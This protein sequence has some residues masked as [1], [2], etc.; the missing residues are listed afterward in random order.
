MHLRRILLLLAL[1]AAASAQAPRIGRIEF[2]GLRKV[3]EAKVRKALGLNVG[4]ALPRSK[5]AVEERLMEV[6]GIVRAHLEATCCDEGKVVLYVGIEERGAPHFDLRTP[7][8]EELSLPDDITTAYRQFLSAVNQAVRRNSTAED[9][10]NGHSLMADPDCRDI[11]LRFVDLAEKHL[12]ELRKV[13][14][15]SGDDEQRAIAAYVIGYAPKKREIVDDLL[16]ALKDEDD[17]VRG[18]ATRALAAVGVYAKLNPDAGVKISPTWFIEML[19]SLSWT[20]RNNAA[21]ALVNL[22]ETR[23]ASTLEQIR[24]RALPSLIE[25]ARFQYLQHALPAYILVGRVA[26]M[27]EQEI[28]DSWSKGDRDRVIAAATRKVKQ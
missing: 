2:Y 5:P 6:P 13:L 21:V 11:Q 23:D 15:E 12:M 22:T 18:N 27:P 19:N 26:G 24:E 8:E 14:R 20:D 28:Q 3:P 25:M 4:D 1:A 16:Y 10:T 9:L 7:P 17:T